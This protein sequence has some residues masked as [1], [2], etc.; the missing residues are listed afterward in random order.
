MGCAMIL[1]TAFGH[2]E[3][4]PAP[5]GC[6]ARSARST[7]TDPAI[8]RRAASGCQ[9]PTVAVSIIGTLAASTGEPTKFVTNRGLVWYLS[10]IFLQPDTVLTVVMCQN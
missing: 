6:P 10:P 4:G 9:A 5:L 2:S 8:V 7:A 3:A 1:I